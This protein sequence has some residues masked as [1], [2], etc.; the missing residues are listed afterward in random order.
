MQL[1]GIDFF[2]TYA[3]VVQ[4]TT[5]WLMF[6]LEVLLGLKSKQGNVTC[7]FLH[8]DL[9]PGESV[10]F[11]MPLGFNIKSKN[12]KH[13]VLKFKKTLYGFCQIHRAFR[14]Y[15]TEKLSIAIYSN[16]SLIRVFSS[17]L[18]LCALFMLTT[19]YFGVTM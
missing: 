16:P 12:G 1:E 9:E 4:L 19:L 8:A 5:I 14:K 6:I 15:I 2:E 10:Y 11:G 13:Q 18:M 17:D 3:P 7:A